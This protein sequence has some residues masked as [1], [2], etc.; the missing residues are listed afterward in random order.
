LSVGASGRATPSAEPAPRPPWARQR[1]RRWPLRATGIGLALGLACLFAA[2]PARA[3]ELCGE[4]SNALMRSVGI[5]EAQIERLCHKVRQATALLA[6][7]LVRRENELGYCRVTLALRNNATEYVNSVTLTS[8]D[9][10]FEN[11]RFGNVLPGGTAYASALSR[12]PLACD[13]LNG[14]KLTFL[15]PASLRVGDRPL[16]GRLLEHYKPVLLDPLLRWKQ[17]R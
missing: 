8:L 6:V 4:E 10:R 9:A 13:E 2:A 16:G 1:R 12:I 7:S 5:S 11:F 15:W 14:V 3:I 17:A